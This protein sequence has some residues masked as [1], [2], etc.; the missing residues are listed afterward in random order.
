MTTHTLLLAA[1]E[2]RKIPAPPYVYGLT[3]LALLGILLLVT[4]SFNRDR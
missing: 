2:K 3:V 4:L 1:E